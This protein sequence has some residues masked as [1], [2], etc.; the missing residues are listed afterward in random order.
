MKWTSTEALEFLVFSQTEVQLVTDHR[1]EAND[2]TT[3]GHVTVE[4]NND[5][6]PGLS[7]PNGETSNFRQSYGG[8]STVSE[9]VS[10]PS[11]PGAHTVEM[12]YASEK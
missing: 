4:L 5:S 11:T 12:I 7:L 2:I 9:A 3:L 6:A 8:S 1:L 10:E